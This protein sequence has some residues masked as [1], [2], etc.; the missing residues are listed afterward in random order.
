MKHGIVLQLT[1]THEEKNGITVT[2]SCSFPFACQCGQHWR[3]A[4]PLVL[5]IAEERE[6]E[7]A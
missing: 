6:K 2:D 1:V 3:N 5:H 7:A 4:K